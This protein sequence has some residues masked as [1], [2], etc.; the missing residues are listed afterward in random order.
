[1]AKID[2]LYFPSKH[3]LHVY[4]ITLTPSAAVSFISFKIMSGEW[5]FIL[6][7][8]VGK[9]GGG[10]YIRDNNCRWYK[11]NGCMQQWRPLVKAVHWFGRL[12]LLFFVRNNPVQITQ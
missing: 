9:G 7:N 12:I 6:H 4:Y 3:A 1:M 11:E 2:W 8:D 5:D 10:V